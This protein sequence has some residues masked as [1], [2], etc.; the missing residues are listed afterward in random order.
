L[1][2]NFN[3]T[4]EIKLS[5]FLPYLSNKNIALI[6][7]R[8]EGEEG[9]VI[10]DALELIDKYHMPFVLSEFNPNFLKRHGT[11]PKKYIEL[12]IKNGYKISY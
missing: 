7:L 4:F 10:G 8:I 9:I 12:F 11:D 5:N 6:K 2:Y 1:R 3:K